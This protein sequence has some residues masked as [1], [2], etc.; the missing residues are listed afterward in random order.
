LSWHSCWYQSF[1]ISMWHWKRMFFDSSV[2]SNAV[3][4][5]EPF[6]TEEVD[7]NDQ[8]VRWMFGT[9]FLPAEEEWLLGTEEMR[10]Y[11]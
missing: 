6:W 4:R 8:G 3:A 9:T 5:L 7:D 11:C 10:I 2:F 1:S